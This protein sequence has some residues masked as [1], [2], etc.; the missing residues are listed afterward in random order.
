[1]Y[2]EIL[3]ACFGPKLVRMAFAC[4]LGVPKCSQIPVVA[5]FVPSLARWRLP[6]CLRRQGEMFAC[7]SCLSITKKFHRIHSAY[8]YCITAW[9]ASQRVSKA[10]HSLLKHVEALNGLFTPQS[11]NWR[12]SP[13]SILVPGC[14]CVSSSIICLLVPCNMS[15]TGGSACW[16]GQWQRNTQRWMQV[17]NVKPN[18]TA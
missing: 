11:S 10:F 16:W 1:M 7:L 9:H 14:A 12:S 15:N 18:G 4:W 17:V 8:V 2:F 6:L 5:N 13:L 3:W